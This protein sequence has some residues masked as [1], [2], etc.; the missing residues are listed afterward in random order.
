M[1]V[2][3]V[4]KCQAGRIELIA[5][6]DQI[7]ENDRIALIDL[8]APIDRIALIDRVTLMCL[9]SPRRRMRVRS[10]RRCTGKVVITC[11]AVNSFMNITSITHLRISISMWT[12]RSACYFILYISNNMAAETVRA[13]ILS[14]VW[15]AKNPPKKSTRKVRHDGAVYHP[16]L[17][18]TGLESTEMEIT[19]NENL[20][21]RLW[22]FH[23]ILNS[24][25]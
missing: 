4:E 24:M 8:I 22:I 2:F 6:I 16:C 15:G 23:R 19:K 25:A 9:S 21:A 3:Q 18:W 10:A 1:V 12:P 5:L 7:A 20:L 17:S 13:I 14:C 11:N